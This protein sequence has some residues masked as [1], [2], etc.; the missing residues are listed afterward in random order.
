MI[1]LPKEP[2]FII[3]ESTG[4]EGRFLVVR[5]ISLAQFKNC[6]ERIFQIIRYSI[7]RKQETKRLIVLGVDSALEEKW[8]SFSQ[9]LGTLRENVLLQIIKFFYEL[10]FLDYIL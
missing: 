8:F 9:A 5:F 3:E 4:N 7:T 1:A 10:I 6:E 2:D